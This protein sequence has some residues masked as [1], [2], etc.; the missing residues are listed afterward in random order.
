MATG[1]YGDTMARYFRPDQTATL[2]AGAPADGGFAVTRV[3]REAPGHGKNVAPLPCEDAFLFTLQLRDVNA[4]RARVRDQPVGSARLLSGALT[5]IDMR[6]PP[7]IHVDSPFD[8]LVFYLSR[9]ALDQIT[10]DI[11]SGRIDH[12]ACPLLENLPDPV[13]HQLGRCFL[14]MLDGTQEGDPLLFDHVSWALRTHLVFRYAHVRATPTRGGLAP[15]QLRLAKELLRA[16]L[17]G[18][19][20]LEQ[21]ASECGL[22]RGHFVRAFHQ[23]TGLPPHRWLKQR[24]IER[25]QELLRAGRAPLREVAHAAGFADASHLTRVF[26]RELGVSPAHYRRLVRP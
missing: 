5:L 7:D 3:L 26:H 19:L 14:A 8:S 24:R 10:Q 13:A 12:F 16:H 23:S 6:A 11:G 25:A 22:S 1:F 20:S 15:R 21:L 4:F 9:P 2:L 18:N 17:Q